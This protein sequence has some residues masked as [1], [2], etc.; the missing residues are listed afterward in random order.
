MGVG[1]SREIDMRAVTQ[2]V[3]VS[4]SCEQ[5]ATMAFLFFQKQLQRLK[6]Y[7]SQ[8]IVNNIFLF[9]SLCDMWSA[10]GPGKAC[11]NE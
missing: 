3:N 2:R 9:I 7:V 6:F 11:D 5:K 8:L 1:E 4:L 10:T